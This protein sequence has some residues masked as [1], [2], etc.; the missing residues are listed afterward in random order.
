MSGTDGTEAKKLLEYRQSQDHPVWIRHVL[1]PGY[2]LEQD[3]LER[4]ADYLAPFTCI[5]RVEHLPFHQLGRHKWSALGIPYPLEITSPPDA[6]AV[7]HAIE[8]FQSRG[9]NLV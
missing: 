7:T 5:Q 2:T 3:A 9:L 4:L 1:V 6:K 8:I